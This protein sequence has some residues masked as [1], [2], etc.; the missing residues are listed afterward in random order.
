MYCTYCGNEIDN[1]ATFCNH[2]GKPTNEPTAE[3]SVETP[4]GNPVAAL[5]G[6]VLSSKSFLT[7]TVL[8]TVATA[9]SFLASIAS[10][11]MAT[12]PI[13]NVI[14][15][16]A[17]FLLRSR[18][19][20]CVAHF[21]Y[22]GPLK[23]L[24]VVTIITNVV[25]WIAAVCLAVSGGLLLICGNVLSKSGASLDD[26][27][28]FVEMD[29]AT[30]GLLSGLF[31]NPDAS[32]GMIFTVLAIIF[33]IVAVVLAIIAILIY[34]RLS[35]F[36]KAAISAANT[37][38]FGELDFSIARKAAITHG[39]FQ[40]FAAFPTLIVI[41]SPAGVSTAA[42]EVLLIISAFTFAKILGNIKK[43]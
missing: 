18:A 12:I 8:F 13:L 38:E 7:G 30:E 11:G 41:L 6:Q 31:S 9:L 42:A 23:A 40:I 14:T 29:A 35:K 4:V 20:N 25:I 28:N 19:N 16:I 17:L 21:E 36:L 39:V 33:I 32:F 1:A 27:S 37:G 43:Q 5:F 3:V 34:G 22:A 10:S 26:V 2:C 15:I 24:R